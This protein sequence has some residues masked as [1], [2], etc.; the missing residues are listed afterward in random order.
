ML[1]SLLSNVFV[2]HRA[3]AALASVLAQSE[4]ANKSPARDEA[5]VDK[6]T[7]RPASPLIPDNRASASSDVEITGSKLG[8]KPSSSHIAKTTKP[9]AAPAEPPAGKAPV[10]SASFQSYK[11]LDSATLFGE[12]HRRISEHRKAEDSVLVE[13][14]DK[15]E[16]CAYSS[17]SP[18][19]P[20]F[21][22]AVT[23]DF[24]KTCLALCTFG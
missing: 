20:S 8:E 14:Q 5:N 21:R 7:S 22:L 23:R 12:L 1:V 15:F 10:P 4:P 9:E 11:D 18:Q 3:R 24:F 17:S 2:F 19:V 13:L 6:P 16:V